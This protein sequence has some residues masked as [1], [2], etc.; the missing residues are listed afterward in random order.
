MSTKFPDFLSFDKFTLKEIRLKPQ[1]YRAIAD[2]CWDHYSYFANQRSLILDYLKESLSINAI[3]WNFSGWRRVVTFKYALDPLSSKGSILSAPGGR[4]NFGKIDQTKYP[5]F[6]AL[7]IAETHATAY[8]EKYGLYT[9]GKEYDGIS[10]EDLALGGN[11]TTVC[12][13][14]LIN[15]VLD[16]SDSKNLK[17]FFYW[18][19][20]IKLPAEFIKRANKL[21]IEP[22]YQVKSLKELMETI[23][24]PDWRKLPMQVYIPSNSQIL[25]QIA[26]AAG[27]EAILYPSRMS[28]K[29]RCLAI[30]PE[31]FMNSISFVEI[32]GEA[33]QELTN[34]CLDAK[35]Y[36][37]YV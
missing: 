10:A 31:N 30:F 25:G 17:N 7:Y 34:R 4:F 21:N 36:L 19:K 2:Y 16:L 11:Q 20:N 8:K 3:S 26:H 23:L 33:P 24:A 15:Q 29:D 18:I 9:V 13:R 32:E 37:K 27:I 12:V 22:M 14:G 28:A 35:S 6:P 5:M 1:L